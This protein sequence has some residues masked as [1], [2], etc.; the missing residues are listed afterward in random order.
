MTTVAQ[1]RQKMADL[2][3]SGCGDFS[4]VSMEV[5]DGIPFVHD[6]TFIKA[7]EYDGELVIAL[8]AT[9]GRGPEWMP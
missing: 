7:Q 6:L 8:P 1:L 4:V 2:E 5:I 3:A 9:E